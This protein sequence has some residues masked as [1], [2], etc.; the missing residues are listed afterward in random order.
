MHTNVVSLLA[1]EGFAL[2]MFLTLQP[3]WGI[4]CAVSPAYS[5]W[6]CIPHHHLGK[7]CLSVHLLG[8]PKT[9]LAQ[10]RG[11]VSVAEAP[12]VLSGSALSWHSWPVGTNVSAEGAVF[13]C[14]LHL[15]HLMGLHGVEL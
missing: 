5:H 10:D 8:M 13:L 15:W 9:P 2:L 7:A 12:R 11:C 6:P 14:G 4:L 3:I 1:R